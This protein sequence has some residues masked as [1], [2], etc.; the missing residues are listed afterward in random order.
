MYG[1]GDVEEPKKESIREI[2]NVLERLRD[3]IINENNINQLCGSN[4]NNKKMTDKI[5]AN[6]MMKFMKVIFKN[7]W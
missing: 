5:I 1:Y 2:Y 3:L 6:K 7:H 4:N